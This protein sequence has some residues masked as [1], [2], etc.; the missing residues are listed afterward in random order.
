L[1]DHT[2]E[3]IP[4]DLKVSRKGDLLVLKLRTATISI[5]FKRRREVAEAIMALS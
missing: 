5:D 2:N 4:S 1:N 3:N